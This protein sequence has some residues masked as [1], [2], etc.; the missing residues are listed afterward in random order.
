M[1]LK[2]FGGH[3]LIWGLDWKEQTLVYQKKKKNVHNFREFNSA[4]KP[5]NGFL[6]HPRSAR[7]EPSLSGHNACDKWVQPDGNELL[8]VTVIHR[9]SIR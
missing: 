9:P 7:E 3:I 8:L 4:L 1:F 5:I 6:Q 2:I